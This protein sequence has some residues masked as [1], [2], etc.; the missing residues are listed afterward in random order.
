MQSYTVTKGIVAIRL[1]WVHEQI[2]PQSGGF[3]VNETIGLATV[4][5]I[6]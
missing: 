4:K 6:K 3:Y 2:S 1:F 5:Q